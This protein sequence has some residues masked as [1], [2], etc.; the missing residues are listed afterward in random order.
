MKSL[1][2]GCVLALMSVPALAAGFDIQVDNFYVRDGIAT[3]VM[4]VA[5]NTGRTANNV[6]IDCVF[7]DGDNRAIEIGKAMI[8]TIVI[9]GSAYDKAAAVTGDGV[10][11]AQCDVVRSR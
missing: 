11:F 8:P 1:G 7:L 9:G 10:Q 2:M 5:N 3:V 6:F 4:K